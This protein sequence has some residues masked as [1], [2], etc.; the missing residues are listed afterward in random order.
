MNQEKI[1]KDK[2]DK[3]IKE[4]ILNNLNGKFKVKKVT[5]DY[6]GSEVAII[7]E[8][9]FAGRFGKCRFVLI[10]GEIGID[11]LN[12]EE[13]E[14]QDIYGEIFNWI[15]ESEINNEFS[16]ITTIKYKGKIL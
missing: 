4:K 7:I 3:E 14:G 1:H 2:K 13:Q 5:R 6:N 16:C 10:G 8:F 12:Y 11:W 15:E 9:L